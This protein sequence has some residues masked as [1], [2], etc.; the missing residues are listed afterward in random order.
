MEYV[1]GIDLGTSSLKGM[2]MD[3]NGLEVAL[4]TH[5]YEV[6]HPQKGFSEQRPADWIQAFITVMQQLIKEVPTVVDHLAGISFSGQM[7][8]LVL[9]DEAGQPLRNAILWNDVRTTKQCQEIMTNYGDLV[10]KVTKNIA[11]EG[12]TLP[13][14]LWVQE[15]EPNLWKR[16]A[17]VLLPKDYLGYWLTGQYQMDYSDAAGTLL[18]DVQQEKWA[19]DILRAFTIPAKILPDLLASTD[20]RGLM[21]PECMASFGFKKAVPVFG[22]GA[23]NAC[24]ALAAG[25]VAPEVGM[26]SIGTSGVFLTQEESAEKNYQGKVHFFNNVSKDT[27]YSMGVTLAAGNSLEWFKQTF[28]NELS[29]DELLKDVATVK[30]GSAGLLFTPYIVGERTPYV[31]SQIRG[32]F[33]GM[34]ACHQLKHFTRSVLEGITFSLKDCQCAIESVTKRKVTKIVSV[35]GGAKNSEWL[36]MQADIFERPVVT[37]RTEQGPALG[38]AML[39]GIGCGWYD[40]Q[41]EAAK[42]L[43]HY[44][45]EVRPVK[46]NVTQYRKMYRIYQEVYAKTKEL[47]HELSSLA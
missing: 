39:A 4:A 25:I 34:D 12:F 26:C 24:A 7:H 19:A 31:D 1:L 27:Y 30:P 45:A 35:G 43:V 17:K 37:L 36:Q 9:L 13:K 10:L 32:S 23:D 2:L 21:R 11:L 16:V 8:S 46:E 20:L 47:S 44:T 42:K 15:N 3:Q 22:G 38:A 33:I 28:A 14:I 18:L 6:L 41:V 5:Q 40:N 29:F